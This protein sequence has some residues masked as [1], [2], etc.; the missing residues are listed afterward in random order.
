MDTHKLF[1]IFNS[2][3]KLS[4]SKVSKLKGNRI[5][6]RNKIKDYFK[7]KGWTAPMFYSQGS[8]PLKTNLN[9]IKKVTEEGIKEEYDLDDG[10]YFF[11]P[12]SDRKEPATYHDRIMKAVKGHAKSEKDKSTC[13]RVIYADGHHIDLPSY[14]LEKDG[15]IP[16]L[17]HKS[18]G[19]TESDPKAFKDWVDSKIST[20]NSNGQLRRLI[21]YFK[22]WKDYREDKNSN[23]KLPSGFI[24]TI[25]ACQNFSKDD[26]DDLALKN[27]TE[28]IK[29]KLFSNFSCYRPTVPKDE[30]LLNNYSKDT[31]LRELDKFFSN[32]QKAINS[33]CE[34]KASGLWRKVFGDRFPLG[35]KKEGKSVPVAKNS[36]LGAVAVSRPFCHD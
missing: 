9:P 16:Q 30:D 3:I 12:E 20:A 27:T 7:D 2:A 19:Y 22:A 21:R 23:L 14:W 26:R 8:F 18:D 10:V 17:T 5:A 15:D 33:D 28:A 36:V 32:A 11:C 31:V 35:K 4:D 25:L 24:L 1:S 13:V 29:N 34:E 6:L